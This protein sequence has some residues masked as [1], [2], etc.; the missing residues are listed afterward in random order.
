M[1]CE[2]RKKVIKTYVKVAEGIY[3]QKSF[4][5]SALRKIRKSFAYNAKIHKPTHSNDLQFIQL[6]KLLSQCFLIAGCTRH[7]YVDVDEMYIHS[8]VKSKGCI[9][10]IFFI[11][12]C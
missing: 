3:L 2:G 6:F 5:V 8:K 1:H 9:C 12:I 10:F 4:T 11:L 7:V